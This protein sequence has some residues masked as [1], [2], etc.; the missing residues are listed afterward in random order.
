MEQQNN[1]AKTTG[2]SISTYV[3][4]IPTGYSVGNYQGKKYGISKTI[5][6]RGKSVK[7]YGEE[8]GGNNFVSLNYYLTTTK[9]LLKPCEMPAQKVVH[10]LKNVQ[11]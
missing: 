8:L 6:N 3:N 7:L 1:T 9:E 5:F 10:F 4:K 11:L 2:N